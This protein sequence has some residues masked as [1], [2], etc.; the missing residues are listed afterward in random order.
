METR[1][2]GVRPLLA[3]LAVLLGGCPSAPP[4]DDPPGYDNITDPTN[5]GAS[6]VG[7][8][9]CR[10][11]HSDVAALHAV[12]GHSFALNRVLGQPPEYPDAAARAGVPDPPDGF[13]WSDVAYVIDGYAKAAWFVDLDG[14][15]LTTGLSGVATQWNL[16]FPPNGTPAGFVEFM[17]DASGPTPF[18][19][20]DFQRYTTGPQPQDSE[21]PRF[22]DN[23]GGLAGTWS[24]TGVQCE[25]CHGPGSNHFGTA[26]GEVD[27]EREFIF[28]DSSGAATCANCHS[29][30]FA[31]STSTIDA[32]D[33]FIVA[34]EQW[35]E[36]QAS[37][38][39]GDFSCTTCHD[40][41]RSIETDRSDA[42]RNECTACHADMTMAGHGGEVFTRGDYSEPLSCESCHMPYA[43]R[44]AS[45]ATAEV[46]G[47]DG[48][49]GDTR[50]H[51][52]RINVEPVG[53]SQ[54]FNENGTSVRLD[55]EGRAAVTVDFACLRCHNGIA[56][57][58]LTLARAAEIAGRI[59]ELE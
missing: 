12:H 16:S 33:G 40:P 27:I 32:A 39:H 3:A 59:H 47:P 6:L 13:D 42:I 8:T 35:A 31:D 14:Y 53:A 30:P 9:S 55:A 43:S 58:E 46:V 7:A 34:F 57:F 18:P 29:T 21:R 56:V 28:V 15:V 48:R 37:G 2:H 17:P 25:A 5:G 44:A 10:E 1:Q 36:L 24:E 50:T 19:F 45:A 23:R 20:A 11:C 49:M 54:F 4:D 52:F 22:Q 26:A 38:G 41:H 51:I